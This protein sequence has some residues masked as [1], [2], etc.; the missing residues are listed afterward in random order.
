V[1]A[2]SYVRSGI[3]RPEERPI[4]F[5]FAGGPGASAAGLNFGLLGPQRWDGEA[6]PPHV[7]GQFREAGHQ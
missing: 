2:T 5:A 3:A 4:I 6:A 1:S 7:V